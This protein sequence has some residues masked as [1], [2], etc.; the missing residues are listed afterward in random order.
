[1]MKFRIKGKVKLGSESREFTKEIE[2]ATENAAMEKA[3]SLIGS[4]NGVPRNKIKFD[5]VEKVES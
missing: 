1:M 2:A 3:Y 5:S 4:N